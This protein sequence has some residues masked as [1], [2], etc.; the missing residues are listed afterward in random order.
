MDARAVVEQQVER[1]VSSEQ[2]TRSPRSCRFLR[3]VVQETNEG[4]GNE[5]KQYLIGVHVFD[6]DESFDPRLDPIVRVQARK[7][8]QRLTQY[9]EGPGVRDPV[10]IELPKRRL[11]A[12]DSHQA[13]GNISFAHED[14]TGLPPQQVHY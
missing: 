13:G 7:L 4:R 5:L 10:V 1:I 2:L 11:P 3:F 8:R 12:P 9:Y 6:R 14:A